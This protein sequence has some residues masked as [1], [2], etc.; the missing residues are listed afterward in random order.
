[1]NYLLGFLFLVLIVLLETSVL[2]FFPIFGVQGNLLLV[3]V[4]ALRFLNLNPESYY[5]AFVGGILLDLLGGWP[6]GLSS[7]LLLL[8]SGTVGL[9]RR[10]ASASPLVLLLLTFGAAV[11]FRLTQAFPLL[12][13]AVLGKG[14]LVDVGVMAVVYPVLKYVLKSLFAR[15]EL[16]IGA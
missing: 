9:V 10:F 13:P 5:S 16:Q 4:L 1:M 12:N 2:P 14:G 11:I 15:R 8:L 3:I 7:S 6:L